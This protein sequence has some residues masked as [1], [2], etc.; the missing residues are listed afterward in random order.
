MKYIVYLTI[1]KKN[2]KIYVG[3]H[4]TDTN[5]FDGYLG[6]GVYANRPGTYKKS[7]TVFQLAVNKYGPDSFARI[8]LQEFDNENDAYDL[9]S[10]IVNE[11]FL[12]R[13]D[14]YNSS[15]GGKGGDLGFSS[16]KMYQY[17]LNGNFIKEFKSCY[18]ASRELGIP[19]A[20]L[21]SAKNNQWSTSGFL[22]TNYKTEKLDFNSYKISTQKRK[23]YQYNEDGTF[24]K[25]FES[26]SDAARS[27][28]RESTAISR[29]IKAGYKIGDKYFLYVHDGNYS[30]SKS[31]YVRDREVH[32]YSLNGD[33]IKSFNNKAEAIK[34]LNLKHD[35]IGNSIK[36]QNAFANFQWSYEKIDRMPDKSNNNF[37]KS[38]KVAQCDLSGE[39]IKIYDSV[40]ECKKDFS[41]CC[42]V[43]SGKRKK[44]KGY[45]F[46]YID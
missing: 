45:F 3:V 32:Q 34:E 21:Q 9:E 2:K 17:D 6:C 38:R 43:L 8:T 31:N 11:S 15:L 24:E 35:R 26:C 36:T 41:S 37:S 29:A 12:K 19:A 4:R 25:E 30:V 42:H 28:G 10:K 1:N 14:V 40:S 46:K 39:I 5:K 23:V 20:T 22:Y 33:Y 27:L 44:A 18:E 7:K 13:K 16:K